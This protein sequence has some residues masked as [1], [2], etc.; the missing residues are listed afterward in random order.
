MKSNSPGPVSVRLQWGVDLPEAVPYED[1]IY[2][3]RDSED[4]I[5]GIEKCISE[6]D[7]ALTEKRKRAVEEETW[8]NKVEHI[9]NIVSET[10]RRKRTKK[11]R[12]SR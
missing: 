7:P 9:S 10:F 12:I 8:E 5:K 1:V 4:F 2:T 11:E 6:N 3:A